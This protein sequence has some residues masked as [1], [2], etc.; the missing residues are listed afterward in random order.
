[1]HTVSTDFNQ[2]KLLSVYVLTDFHLLQVGFHAQFRLLFPL[3]M[4]WISSYSCEALNQCNRIV[5]GFHTGFIH[6]LTAR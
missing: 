6:N 4:T 1:M 3:F 2:D 5:A